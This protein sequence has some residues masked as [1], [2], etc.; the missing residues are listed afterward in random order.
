MDGKVSLDNADPS[1]YNDPSY[2]DFSEDYKIR[3]GVNG[4]SSNSGAED[5]ATYTATIPD[6]PLVISFGIPIATSKFL[7][8]STSQSL[9][10]LQHPQCFLYLSS[11]MINDPNS[12]CFIAWTDLDSNVC[13]FS[14]SNCNLG[15]YFKHNNVSFIYCLVVASPS[16]PLI[17]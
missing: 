6:T 14:R 5:L 1:G 13:E 15:S 9:S 10:T 16:P 8:S 2:V 7:Q 11:R 12:T 17:L 3:R 4:S